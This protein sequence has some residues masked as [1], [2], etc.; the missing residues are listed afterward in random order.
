MM[1][2]CLVFAVSEPAKQRPA[3]G[4]PPISF[5][6]ELPALPTLSPDK[7][8]PTPQEASKTA[9]SKPEVLMQ[10]AKVLPQEPAT[11]EITTGTLEAALNDIYFDYDRFSIRDD[12]MSLL[13]VNA[14][15]LTAKFADKHI[16][17]EGHCDERGTQ[18]YNMVLGERRAHAVKSFLEDLGVPA[19]NL[20][21][22][23][24]GKD[25][26]FCTEPTQECWQE[27]RRGHFLIQ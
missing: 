9:V 12:A 21:A 4:I 1:A 23:S 10:L 24:Y 15:L 20:Q 22:V 3:T 17:I 27:N 26:P 7:V 14:Q 6:P 18:S 13:K 25:K 11:V 8:S 2:I 16:V 5:E 19:E